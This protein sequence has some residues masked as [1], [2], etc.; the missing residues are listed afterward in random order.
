MVGAFK[1][2]TTNDY[3]RNVKQNDWP[4]FNKKLWQRNYFEHIIRDHES[5]LKISEYIH[6]NPMKWQEDKY[7]G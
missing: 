7:F 5:Y 6:A 3:I 2:V 1:S 4:R